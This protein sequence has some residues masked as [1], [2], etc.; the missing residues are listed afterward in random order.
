MFI[1][2]CCSRI[3]AL[4]SRRLEFRGFIVILLLWCLGTSDVCVF[5]VFLL[6]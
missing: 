4:G 6:F 3:Q 5:N 1:E 2:T